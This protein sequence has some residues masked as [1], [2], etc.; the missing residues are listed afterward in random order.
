MTFM[1]SF[2]TRLARLELATLG[3]EIRCSIRLSYRRIKRKQNSQWST[4]Y[5]FYFIRCGQWTKDCGLH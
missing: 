1:V 5:S 3:L 2:F 4:R